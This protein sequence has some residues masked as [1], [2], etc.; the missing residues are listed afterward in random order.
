MAS[1]QDATPIPYEPGNDL[2]SLGGSLVSDGS[3]TV[4]PLTEAVAEEFGIMLSE[5]GGSEVQVEVSISG[6]GS[7]FE[8][9]CAGETDLQNASR[10]ISEEEIALCQQG[11][12]YYFE[13]EVAFDGIAV[14][15]N[16]ENDFVECLTVEQL[17]MMWKPEGFAT[18]WNEIDP[19]FPEEPIV[20][21]G[22]GTD[23]GTFDYFTN[24]INGEEGA[25][26]T[27]YSP[28]EDDNQ[29]VLGVA[30]DSNAL[31][32]FGLAYYENNADQLKLVAVDS[33]SGCVS[34]SAETVADGSYA[35][36]SRPLFVYLN[37]ESLGRPE[38]QEFARFWPTPLLA[39]DVGYVSSPVETYL[40]DQPSW[41][42]RLP[43]TPDGPGEA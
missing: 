42:Q 39:A 34:P 18:M 6:T 12:V 8:R 36:L 3:S 13:F 24:A 19:S 30:G 35:P 1:A 15:V 25:S 9:F 26:M 33:G 29:L 14:V 5:E 41:R 27:D 32:Y 28:S 37:A 7:G 2:A 21:Y 31:G 16:P 43:A 20:L 10:A 11:G 38:V 40:E 4:G 22:P 23:S 17:N